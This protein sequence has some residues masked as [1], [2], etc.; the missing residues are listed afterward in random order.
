MTRADTRAHREVPG[1]R[2][3]STG[4]ERDQE[5]GNDYFG[6]RYYA[7]SVGRWMSP[8]PTGLALA[9][10]ENP[11]SLN[12]YAYVNNNPLSMI[13]PDGL[14]VAPAM[15][16]HP[17]W[18]CVVTHFIKRI[19]SGGGGGGGGE[20]GGGGGGGGWSPTPYPGKNIVN[21]CY[22]HA[23]GTVG[24]HISAGTYDS[25]ANPNDPTAN[26]HNAYGF[27]T[28]NQHWYV[29]SMLIVG[30]PFFKGWMEPDSKSPRSRTGA[31]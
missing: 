14:Q 11:Q 27:T 24:G 12:L 22:P 23:A 1:H 8:D 5:S 15:E 16:C 26:P 3:R 30:F 9:T 10:A 17:A 29:R 7:S 2:S 31:E 13:D 25:E 18:L 19:F 4:K 28:I 20:G 6:A 21:V